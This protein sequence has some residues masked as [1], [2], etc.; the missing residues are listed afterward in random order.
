L[1]PLGSVDLGVF[2]GG[3]RPFSFQPPV[4]APGDKI[5]IAALRSWA[6][7]ATVLAKANFEETV[8][9]K[10]VEQLERKNGTNGTTGTNA[11][12]GKKPIANDV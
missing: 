2:R 5:A 10:A 1:I 3:A 6:T 9:T 7:A 8:E 11:T 12:E 4:A